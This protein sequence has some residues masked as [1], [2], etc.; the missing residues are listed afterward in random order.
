MKKPIRVVE[1]RNTESFEYACEEVVED[2]YV[3]LQAGHFVS[4]GLDW[5]YA[6]FAHA[7]LEI[8]CGHEDT[9]RRK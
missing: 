7:N 5:Y 4:E 9:N 1:K 6:I 8:G 2:G 3:L